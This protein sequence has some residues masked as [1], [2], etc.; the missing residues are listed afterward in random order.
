MRQLS[1]V[2]SS[3]WSRRLLT[4]MALA[5]GI[6]GDVPP[7]QA[8]CDAPHVIRGDWAEAGFVEVGAAQMSQGGQGHGPLD[9]GREA[10]GDGPLRG[11]FG[12]R[13]LAVWFDCQLITE[14]TADTMRRV[15][16]NLLQKRC[17]MISLR[18]GSTRE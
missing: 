1:A 18:D 12:L 6:L 16:V 9:R 8:A 17:G 10:T 5:A 14:R 2:P 15:L 11:V 7:A 4:S 3:R 13:L